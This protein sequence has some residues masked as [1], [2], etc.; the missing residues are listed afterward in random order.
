MTDTPRLD[1]PEIASGQSDKSVT[2]NDALQLLDILVQTAVIDKDDTAP[3]G[4]PADGDMY[5]VASGGSGAWS[6]HDGEIAYYRSGW[7]FREPREGYTV[8]VSDED[9]HYTYDGA[10]W[11]AGAAGSAPSGSVTVRA[12]TTANITI[13]TALNNGDSLD[14]VTLATDDMVLVK[15]Q[16]SAAENGIYVVAASP[17]RAEGFDTYNEHPGALISV[18]EGTVNA[19]TV[20]LCTSNQG[21]TLNSTAIAFGRF[22]ANEYIQVASSD[23][24]TDITTGAAKVSF[25][26]PFAMSLTSVRGS[27]SNASSAGIV[28]VDI[29][30]SGSTIFSTELTIDQGEKTSLT[31]DVPAVISDAALADDAEITID[32]VDAGTDA[33]GLK[34]TFIG[35]RA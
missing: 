23:E 11:V 18:Q 5:I 35:L 1:L 16:S 3:P 15:N 24:G 31:A 13:A 10:A 17:A 21:G 28:T 14:G 6:G 7:V 12:A 34:V 22:G 32:I 9:L 27:L 33:K 26:M 19:D 25:R 4:S 2:H 20:W 30:E 8:W 29:N